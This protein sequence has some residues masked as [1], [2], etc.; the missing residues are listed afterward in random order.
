MDREQALQLKAWSPNEEEQ[1]VLDMS[2][3]DIRKKFHVFSFDF[4]E[5]VDRIKE[6]EQWQL[7]IVAHLY[8][9]HVIDLILREA[10]PNPDAINLNR[11]G[12][13]SRLDL[14]FALGLLSTEIRGAMTKITSIRNAVAHKLNFK[15]EDKCVRDLES[16]LPLEMRR[17]LCSDGKKTTGFQLN[18]LLALVLISCETSRQLHAE[19]RFVDYRQHLRRKKVMEEYRL[20][21][22]R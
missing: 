13:S 17:G 3:D 14:T 2:D 15:I 19:Q 8:F 9:E 21:R 20:A 22:I 12:Y 1:S 18:D 11:M 5:F 6:G 10:L 16:C 7:I 4:D